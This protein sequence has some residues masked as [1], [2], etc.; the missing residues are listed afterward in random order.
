MG[1]FGFAYYGENPD[2]VKAVAIDDGDGCVAPSLEA[3]MN[4]Q[5]TPLSRPL[6]IY[7]ADWGLE[8]PE[9]RDFTRFFVEQA[10]TDLVSD[11]GYVPITEETRD[12]DLRRLDAAIEEV[13]A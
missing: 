9:V 2:Q 10:A 3:A 8:E 4:G 13:T 12:E 5:Y 6:F 11:V 7:V 1:Y